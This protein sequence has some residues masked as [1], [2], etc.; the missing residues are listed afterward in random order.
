[1]EYK[2]Y[3]N[4]PCRILVYET[5][6]YKDH[7]A[8]IKFKSLAEAYR[9][10]QEILIRDTKTAPIYWKEINSLSSFRKYCKNHT[11][12]RGAFFTDKLHVDRYL[13]FFSLFQS[14]C[15]TAD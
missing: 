7:I 10:L 4:K 6:N 15:T 1:M 2:N 11:Y 3:T 9:Y 8:T 14:P 5:N 13:Y 12:F